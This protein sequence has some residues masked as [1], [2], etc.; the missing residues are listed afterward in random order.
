MNHDDKNDITY[1]SS[2]ES[3]IYPIY[4]IQFHPEK[5]VFEWVQN[6]NIPHTRNAIKIAQYFLE[7]FLNETRKNVNKFLDEKTEQ[8]SLIYNY[9]V[10]YS[11][12]LGSS[13]EQL[14]LFDD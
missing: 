8:E 5:N 9:P 11:S 12:K 13:Y 7:V 10:T 4:G 6:K 2:F 3:R 1:V 14:Y